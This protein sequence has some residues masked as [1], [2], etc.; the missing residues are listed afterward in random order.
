MAAR[1]RPVPPRTFFLNEQHELAPTS[2]SGGGRAARYAGVDWQAR[3]AKLQGSLH[4]VTQALS[5]TGDPVAASR[6][7]LYA[8]PAK[9]V[10]KLSSDKRKAPHGSFLEPTDF[11]GQ[12][13]MALGRIGLDL[14]GVDDTGN[15]TVHADHERLYQLANSIGALPNA[16]SRTTNRWIVVDSFRLIPPESRVDFQWLHTLPK[17]ELAE[18]IIELQPLLRATEAQGLIQ[19]VFGTLNKRAGERFTA[20]G[21]DF[22]GRRWVRAEM[23]PSTIEST[24]VRYFSVQ[25]LHPPIFFDIDSPS[26]ASPIEL[27][28]KPP[29]AAPSQLPVVGV[30]DTGVPTAHP[31][32]APFRRPGGYVRPGAPMAH[33]GDHGS[34]VAS[35]V[36][37]GDVGPPGPVEGTCA[38]YDIMIASPNGSPELKSL[39][40][41]LAAVVGTERGVRVFNLSLGE[42]QTLAQMTEVERREHLA[43]L[44]DLD[45]FAVQNDVLLV[46]AAGNVRPGIQPAKAYPQHYEDPSWR[47]SALASSFNGLTCGG[48]AYH[49]PAGALAKPWWPSPFARVGPGH[50]GAPVPDFVEHAGNSSQHYTKLDG[51]GVWTCNSWGRWINSGATSWA[52]PLL[53]REAAFAFHYLE[54]YCANGRVFAAT[55]KAYLMAMAYPPV[56]LMNA[57]AAATQGRGRTSAKALISPQPTTAVFI[58]QGILGGPD[59]TVQI[60]VPI[61][62]E[63]RQAA[64]KPVVHLSWAWDTPVNDAAPRVWGCR[65]VSI[66]LH[67]S[68]SARALRGGKSHASGAYPLSRRTYDI[69]KSS[70][71][72]KN[73]TK[74]DD[75]WTVRLKYDDIAEYFP[76][77]IFSEEQ[78]VA[79]CLVLA[80]E[81]AAPVS[82]Q[83]AVQALPTAVSMVHLSAKVPTAIPIQLRV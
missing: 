50:A 32:L 3:S 79:F 60:Q 20:D 27:P 83:P 55:V 35:V 7:Y 68:P 39:I 63:W 82:P 67:P 56:H 40:P 23:Y 42:R 17:T 65:K 59:D 48:F 53:A 43:L 64:S 2:S 41:A 10:V 62:I 25:S 78:R 70:L 37:F 30:V 81:S 21:T 9:E 49:T 18:V 26:A 66:T 58:W 24:A 54:P 38:F 29:A 14:L 77:L 52:T 76:T 73:I 5:A 69:S 12:H 6:Y 1:R 51:A 8:V 71:N 19:A 46:V 34:Q 31:V 22:S 44:R 16:S 33:S 11:G 74:T 47:I 13:S 36:A 80:D 57:L 75:Y 61:P 45:N 72:A 4:S 15:A 28:T